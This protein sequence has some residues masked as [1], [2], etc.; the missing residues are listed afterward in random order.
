MV[1]E[2]TPTV[3]V[4]SGFDPY[5]GAGTL[6][7]TKTIHDLGGYALCAVTALTAQNSH[8][9]TLVEPVAPDTLRAQLET[10]LEDIEVDA[11]KI[12]MLANRALIDVVAETIRTY[13]LS[14][15]I[16][17]PVLV[18]S[19]GTP[20]L[21]VDAMEQMIIKL[22]PLSRLVTPNLDEVN[23][24]LHA[25]YKGSAKEVPK[26][27]E[28]LFSR[29]A[30]NILIKGG[31]MTEEEAV[32]HLVELSS[33]SRFSTPRIETSHT[34]G[35]GCLLSSAIATFLAKGD[36]LAQSV[37]QAKNLLYEK[38]KHASSLQL[39]YVTEDI[40]RKEPIF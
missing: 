39:H 1:S 33:I 27:A 37:K 19:S 15:I 2:N 3:L 8:E 22:F 26:M 24:L 31:H 38:M 21:E 9:V 6:A 36:T 30:R 34:H 10:L 4:I 29:G 14:N 23:A 16:L 5:G 32:D 35:T 12:G 40:K 13:K 25:C 18:S 28:G 7:D 20:L 11:V 17:D